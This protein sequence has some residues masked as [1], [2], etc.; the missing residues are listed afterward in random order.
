MRVLTWIVDRSLGRAGGVETPLGVAPRYSDL[1][2]NGLEFG[3]P[4]FAQIMSIDGSTWNK[5]LASHDQ[6]FEKIGDKL[7][8]IL[9][10]Q[11]ERLGETWEASST[12]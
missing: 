1:N 12:A 11:R 4:K 2:W 8:E 9:R 10:V 6:L 5:E 7:P 3:Q